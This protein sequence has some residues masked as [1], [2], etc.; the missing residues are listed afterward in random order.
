[1]AAMY[2]SAPSIEHQE[3]PY[4]EGAAPQIVSILTPHYF[5]HNYASIL[6]NAD[7]DVLSAQKWMGHSDIKTTLAIYSHL[8]K[9]KEDNNA[10]KLDT[11]F[12]NKVAEKLPEHPSVLV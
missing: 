9:G 12:S 4:S 5:R 7:V 1:M 10:R 11:A 8:G 6:Y 3:S 2:Q